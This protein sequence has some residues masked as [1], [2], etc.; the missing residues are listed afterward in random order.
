[1]GRVVNDQANSELA[2]PREDG[3]KPLALDELLNASEGKFSVQRAAR[4]VELDAELDR[5]RALSERA[6][7]SSNAG[8]S[9]ACRS[10]R[11]PARCRWHR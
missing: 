3:R 7:R 6:C 4:L 8:S 11:P 1:M 2:A 5:L 10:S 9:P